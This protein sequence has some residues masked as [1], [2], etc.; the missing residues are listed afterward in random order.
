MFFLL[1]LRKVKELNG[2]LSKHKNDGDKED[3]LL[4]SDILEA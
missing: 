2:V 1:L 3:A 4:P